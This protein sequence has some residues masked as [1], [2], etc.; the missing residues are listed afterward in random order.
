MFNNMID[1]LLFSGTPCQLFED[2]NP[3]WAPS[4]NLG[5]SQPCHTTQSSTRYDC[6]QSR[7]RR[8]QVDDSNEE[9]CGLSEHSH[10]VGN[11]E[12]LSGITERFI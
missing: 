7:K 6:L 10:D 3:D 9:E 5:Y 1:T 12:T 2:N 4:L 8:R 11:N